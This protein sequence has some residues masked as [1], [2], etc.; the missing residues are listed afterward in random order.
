MTK[1]KKLSSTQ[2][3]KTWR[4]KLTKDHV[5]SLMRSFVNKHLIECYLWNQTEQGE[6]L[7]DE[8]IQLRNFIYRETPTTAEEDTFWPLIAVLDAPWR[9]YD[10]L[11]QEK[12]GISDWKDEYD[13]LCEITLDLSENH[14][15]ATVFRNMIPSDITPE[16]VAAWVKKQ[17]VAVRGYD[18]ADPEDDDDGRIYINQGLI[19]YLVG[20]FPSLVTQRSVIRPSHTSCNGQCGNCSS[21][22]CKH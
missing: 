16:E 22:T 1:Y 2:A 18:P 17:S 5:E 4:D 10:E 15:W 3:E 9:M 6:M 8:Q 12:T 13:E 20:M 11:L 7:A 21:D 19:N 14:D